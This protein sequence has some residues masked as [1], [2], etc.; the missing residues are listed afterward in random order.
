[1]AT[2]LAVIW[3]SLINALGGAQAGLVVALVYN[4]VA[5][6]LGGLEINVE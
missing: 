3:S 5:G 4:V 1:M 6:M 2:F